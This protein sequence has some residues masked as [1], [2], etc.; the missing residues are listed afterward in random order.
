MNVNKNKFKVVILT[1]TQILLDEEAIL[2]IVP[3][4]EG[5]F[6]V[7]AN[8]APLTALLKGGSIKIYNEDQNTLSHEIKVEGGFASIH[9]NV[10]RLLAN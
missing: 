1:P 10:C 3:G 8:H 7:L 5:E 4:S 9:D 6:G 2:V